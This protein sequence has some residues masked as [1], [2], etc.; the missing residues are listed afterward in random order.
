M[1]AND[2]LYPDI[3]EKIIGAAFAVHN[4]LGKGLTEKTYENAFIVKLQSSALHI[5]QQK[6]LPI[7]FEN[8]QVGEQIVD[9]LVENKIIIEI[10]AVEHLQKN[11]ETQI[12]GY[13]KNTKFQV[14]LLINFGTRVEFKRFVHSTQN[15][16]RDF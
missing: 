9:L 11:H 12:L 8:K 5:E 15:K 3:T 13:L 14:G 16:S 7:V 10:K 6:A 4:S 2:L 1:S